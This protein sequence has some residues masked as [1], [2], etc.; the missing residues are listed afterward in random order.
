MT[1]PMK[2]SWPEPKPKD[3]LDTLR[4]A[5]AWK[6]HDCPYDACSDWAKQRI[7]MRI[8]AVAGLN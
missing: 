1:S 2:S 3:M 8:K 6:I 4:D 5:L 7:D